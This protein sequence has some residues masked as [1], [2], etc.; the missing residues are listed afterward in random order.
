MDVVGSDDRDDVS[1]DVSPSGE[2][3]SDCY[4]SIGQL[5]EGVDL[6]RVIVDLNSN[7]KDCKEFSLKEDN[8]GCEFN[9][10]DGPI[11]ANCLFVA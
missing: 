1:L 6:F 10:D 5:R 9:L 7:N 8:T 3:A 4:D 2:A 11:G